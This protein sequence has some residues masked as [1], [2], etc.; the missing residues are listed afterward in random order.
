MHEPLYGPMHDDKA[1]FLRELP[2]EQY[3]EWV[4]A[5]VA[6][7]RVDTRPSMSTE[8]V[9]QLLRARYPAWCKNAAGRT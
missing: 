4:R 2:Q 3:D 7:A 9:R 8:Q 1:R 6:A 5:K